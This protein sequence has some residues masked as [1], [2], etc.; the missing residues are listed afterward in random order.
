MTHKLFNRNTIKLSYSCVRNMKAIIDSHNREILNP[1]PLTKEPCDCP[2]WKVC[3]FDRIDGG[4]NAKQVIYQY[5]VETDID[6]AWNGLCGKVKTYY[7]QTERAL[8]KRLSEHRHA[9]ENEDSQNATAL[10]RYIWYLKHQGIKFKIK[11]SIK[12]RASIY[13]SGSRRCMLCLQEKLAIAMHDPK[14]LLNK[15]TEILH[16]CIHKT[17]VEIRNC[18]K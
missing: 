5:D 16:K 9:I 6:V 7:G 14:T 15:K 3:Y 12:C 13:K 8:K 4:C 2:S 10:S 11:I 18:T 17:K 1:K